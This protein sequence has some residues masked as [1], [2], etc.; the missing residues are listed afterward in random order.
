MQLGDGLTQNGSV[1]GNIVDNGV[2]NFNNLFSQSITGTISGSGG[3]AKTAG[4][5]LVFVT[6][7]SYTGGTTITGGMLQYGTAN[8]LPTTGA[9]TVAGGQLDLGGTG[10]GNVGSVTLQ[11]GLI[12]GQSGDT[13]TGTSFN[14]Q[15]GTVSATSPAQSAGLTMTGPGTAVLS[16]TNSYGGGTTVSGGLLQ[17]G[18]AN[19]LPS[20]GAVTVSGGQLDLNGTTGGSVGSLTLQSGSI[21]GQNADTLS[22]T[23]LNLQSGMISANLGDNGGTGLVKTT[24][25]TVTLSGTNNTY[26]GGTSIEGGVLAISAAANLGVGNLTLGA[27]TLQTTGSY[28]LDGALV[29]L[30][31]AA[32]A[33]D[34]TGTND[35]VTLSAL[36]TGTGGLTKAGP[37]DLALANAAGND[38]SGNT[39]VVAGKLMA[40]ADNALSPNSNL[41]I[42]D[43]ASVI[44]DFGGGAGGTALAEGGTF[45]PAWAAP[46]ISPAAISTVPEPGTWTL[47]LVAVISSLGMWYRRRK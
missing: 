17:Y 32:A 5:T 22:A 47:L 3:V 39:Y 19:A 35:M 10:G 45:S 43:G 14:V 42:G 24:G 36:V 34:V 25:G 4:G 16:A 40:Q 46:A 1:T 41:V 20:G 7:A 6:A 11:S 21:I 9:V 38:Y 18:T 12:S 30:T 28:I 23:S 33:I 26:A 15:S 44:L 8:A 37:G 13:L 29:T 27:G 2:L 31:D